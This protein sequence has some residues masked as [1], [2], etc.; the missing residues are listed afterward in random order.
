MPIVLDALKVIRS[1]RNNEK[2][3]LTKP[4]E[5]EALLMVT[6]AVELPERRR[7]G[8]A[9]RGGDGSDD[10]EYDDDPSANMRSAATSTNARAPKN[11]RGALRKG[12]DSDSDFEFDM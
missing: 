3:D 8:E 6:G 4:V 1:S 2:T 7:P 11:V 12:D 10:E 5:L 9:Q